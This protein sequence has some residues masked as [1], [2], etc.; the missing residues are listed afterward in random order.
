MLLGPR[1]VSISVILVTS[2]ISPLCCMANDKNGL[3]LT[4]QVILFSWLFDAPSIDASGWALMYNTKFFTLHVYSQTYPYA[5]PSGLLISNL[6]IF[7][8]PDPWSVGL[9]RDVSSPQPTSLSTQSGWPLL[10]A[11]TSG[12]FSLFTVFQGHL[13][14]SLSFRATSEWGCNAAAIYF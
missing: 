8:L 12:R 5:F 11:L 6:S 10:E 3:I 13:F 9:A 14:S 4:Y 7:Y 1:I 2:F